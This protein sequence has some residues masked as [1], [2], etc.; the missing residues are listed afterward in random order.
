MERRRE[1]GTGR[2]VESSEDDI[3]SYLKRS[4]KR[5][6][7]GGGVK[8]DCSI[9][10]NIF[11]RHSTGITLRTD[12]HKLDEQN[13]APLWFLLLWLLVVEVLHK[14][15]GGP[16]HYFWRLTRRCTIVG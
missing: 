4:A 6:E 1:C 8:R 11:E 2:A 7:F 5:E 13:G 9:Y 3:T 12:L 15:W 14:L 10:R 16:G